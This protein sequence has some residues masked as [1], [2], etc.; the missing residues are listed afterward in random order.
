M[1]GTSD[2]KTVVTSKGWS[3]AKTRVRLNSNSGPNVHES[4]SNFVVSGGTILP[5][6]CRW[7]CF[8]LYHILHKF[9]FE[10]GWT[11][12]AR[13]FGYRGRMNPRFRSRDVDHWGG[14]HRYCSL[15]YQRTFEADNGRGMCVLTRL[16]GSINPFQE[17]TRLWSCAV[18]LDCCWDCTFITW[19]I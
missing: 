16:L 6:R 2:E 15:L 10:T 9:C 11:W 4:D 12:G 13:A 7:Y 19:H 8:Y 3:T 14:T 5:I 18:N 17:R 1:P